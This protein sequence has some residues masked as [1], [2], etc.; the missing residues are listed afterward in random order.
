[1]QHGH[2]CGRIDNGRASGIKIY[3]ARIEQA[4]PFGALPFLMILQ[5]QVELA[6][7]TD[8]EGEDFFMGEF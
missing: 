7:Q 4:E 6:D 2:R 1:M 8:L 3:I 5:Q